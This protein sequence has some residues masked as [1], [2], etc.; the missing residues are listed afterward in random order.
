MNDVLRLGQYV[1]LGIHLKRRLQPHNEVCDARRNAVRPVIA[2][3]LVIG[4][5]GEGVGVY[6][7]DQLGGGRGP[8]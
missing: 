7:L 6:R 2:E 4:W 8:V 3:D 5:V 1:T